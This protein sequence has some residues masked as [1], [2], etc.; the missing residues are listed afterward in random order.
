MQ[1]AGGGA[2]A[3]VPRNFKLLDELEEA[4]KGTKGGADVSLGIS[5]TDDNTL[6]HWNCSIFAQAGG[7]EPRMWTLSLFCDKDY[8]SKPPAIKF[9]SKV[10]MDC[11][12]AK[13]NV[14]RGGARRGARRGLRARGRAPS[15]L[16]AGQLTGRRLLLRTFRARAHAR[17]PPRRR[18]SAPR[19]P[20]RAA[21][22]RSVRSPQVVAAKVPY[23]AS[24]NSTK[25]LIGAC[26]ELKGLIMKAPRQQPP[27]GTNF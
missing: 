16:R 22:P 21:A 25:T 9:S 1:A 10:T 11:L 23:L 7:G 17:P 15:S 24:W 26:N 12:D 14:R 6:S 5:Q 8:P 3:T 18:C 2:G 20:R 19:R 4:E 13:G 27:D